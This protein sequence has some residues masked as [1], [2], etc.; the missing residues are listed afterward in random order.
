MEISKKLSREFYTRHDPI[1][2]ARELL[3]KLLVVPAEDGTRIS[4]FIVETE[5]YIAPEDK[6]SHAFGLRRTTRNE[7][8]YKIG[9]TAYIYFIY[10]MYYQFNVVTNFEDIPHAILIRA[11][12]PFEGIDTMRER[13]ET[14]KDKNLT[15]G[16]G[17]LTIAFGID[18]NLNH[19]DLL[20]N[21]VWIE[22][23]DFKI[24]RNKI[25][26]G[27]RV[28]IDYAEEYTE[29]PWRFWIKDNPFV[30]RK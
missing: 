9:G 4:G 23:T 25:E 18:K 12:Q 13:R 2:V 28:G 20:G 15:S 27:K 29:K 1:I 21:K 30:S 6:A 19:E 3:G 14:D 8:M 17:K 26:S 7:A 11:T 24:T 5:A 10:G 22:E 16:P